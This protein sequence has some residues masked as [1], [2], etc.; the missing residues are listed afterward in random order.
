[1]TR[2]RE[3][4]GSYADVGCGSGAA[5]H[6]L[7]A[8]LAKAGHPLSRVT[9]FDVS[10]HVESLSG[11]DG[12]SFQ[13]G[14][15][16]TADVQFDLVSM[17]DVFEH[18][19]DPLAF[20]K[21][22]AER[23]KY[24]TFHIPLED[25]TYLRYKDGYRHRLRDPGHLLILNIERALSMLCE[26]GLIVIDYAYTDGFRLSRPASLKEGVLY[27]ARTALWKL[28]PAL[29]T[30]TLNGTSLCVVARVST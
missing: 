16:S 11:S 24:M 19:P 10:P 5:T 4:I 23:T 14:D 18:I 27:W 8:A 25:C 22:C 7:A 29:L 30:R 9:G 20:L 21:R 1:M 26:A 28:S 13:H 17:F 6:S 12:L 2:D 3:L 15:F